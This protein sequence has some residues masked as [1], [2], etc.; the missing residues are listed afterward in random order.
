MIVNL[1]RCCYRREYGIILSPPLETPETIREDLGAMYATGLVSHFPSRKTNYGTRSNDYEVT[2]ESNDKTN[3]YLKYD[4]KVLRF[5]CIETK[6]LDSK[7]L[8]LPANQM[9]APGSA[10]RFALSYF[11]SDNK[12]D[13]R[14]VKPSSASSSTSAS[15]SLILE[16]SMLV[17]K[18]SK[19]ARNWRQVQRGQ[20]PRFYQPEDLLCGSIIDIYG[21]EFL[22]INCD[23]FSRQF[24]EKLNINQTEV[25]I[26]FEEEEE[27]IH[28]VPKLGDG[29]LAIGSE[30]DTL[31]TIYGM[32]K[33]QRDIKKAHKNQHRL[34]RCKLV[35][36]TNNIIE[37][38]RVFA[39][40]YYLEDDTL[41]IFE[42][43]GRNSGLI[44]GSF[45]K[46]GKYINLLPLDSDQPRYFIPTDL[47]LGNVVSIIGNEM[48][49]IE[50]DNVSLKFCENCPDEYPMFDPFFICY[51]LM[52]YLKDCRVNLRKLFRES[53]PNNSR[54][55]TKQKCINI[56]TECGIVHQLNDQQ[57]LTLLRRVQSDLPLGVHEHITSLVNDDDIA[58]AIFVDPSTNNKSNLSKN[59]DYEHVY[60]YNELC[61]LLSHSYFLRT[62]SNSGYNTRNHADEI[63]NKLKS[64][65]FDN[66][67]SLLKYCRERHTQWRRYIF[68][69]IVNV[70]ILT[71]SYLSTF[72]EYLDAIFVRLTI[73]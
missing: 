1:R 60:F 18:K 43:V 7:I 28:P 65:G 35:L 73:V 48:K 47:F 11:L 61:D 6:Y 72:S 4:G 59:K 42:E 3:R 9:Y 39:L 53:D 30:E 52:D 69:F 51:N 22:L 29:F 36:C 58:E 38:S 15:S 23:P 68:N 62:L 40:T 2:R 67:K 21:R 50:M 19:L 49:I 57:I 64:K 17:L 33:V 32:P 13:I 12:I 71:Y 14:V 66:L 31:A 46:R 44:G 37:A 16:D 41:Q 10:K 25:P 20:E 34:L 63:K 55:V 24:Y 45:L 26:L 54:M 5:Q 8:E 56:L 70:M 27:I